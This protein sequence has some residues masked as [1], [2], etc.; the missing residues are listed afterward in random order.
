MTRQQLLQDIESLCNDIQSNITDYSVLSVQLKNL[1]KQYMNYGL[2]LTAFERQKCQSLLKTCH[3][4]LSR[5]KTLSFNYQELL[6]D[7]SSSIEKSNEEHDNVSFSYPSL[8]NKSLNISQKRDSQF[9]MTASDSN[10]LLE[11]LE[12]C[13]IVIFVP[14]DL[15]I[16]IR[17]NNLSYCQL[18]ILPISCAVYEPIPQDIDVLHKITKTTT[19]LVGSI[20]MKNIQNCLFYVTFRQL[21]IH[22]AISNIIYMYSPGSIVIE[23]STDLIFKSD[24]NIQVFDFSDPLQNSNNFTIK[25]IMIT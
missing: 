12:N 25:P 8:A 1:E 2:Q 17:M 16:H 11:E 13:K 19:N 3:K 4:E 20:L 24:D 14:Q 15:L 7:E 5:T 6:I 21:R 22:D 10:I 18:Y 9:S 23:S